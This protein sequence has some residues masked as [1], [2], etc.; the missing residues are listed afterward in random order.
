MSTDRAQGS[1]GRA[2]LWVAGAAL[3][4]GAGV[5]L[6]HQARDP[7]V[8]AP[9]AA[10]TDVPV[11]A[12]SAPAAPAPAIPP[13]VSVE[14]YSPVTRAALDEITAS[15]DLLPILRP[16]ATASANG[17]AATLGLLQGAED[18][19]QRAYELVQ[20]SVAQARGAAASAKLDARAREQLT[21]DVE[22]AT[23]RTLI[24][25][26][27]LHEVRI[28]AIATAR[29]L[30][31]FMEE[32][33]E[34]Y[35]LRDGKVRFSTPASQDQFSHFQVNTERILGQEPLA[36]NETLGALAEQEQLL[37]VLNSPN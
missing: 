25:A 11:S 24:L 27:Q 32:N 34:S 28:Q 31:T 36:R 23:S 35:E 1:R 10:P 14:S 13:E 29:S 21:A 22:A 17:R 26:R 12:P 9:A 33:A 5:V 2:R 4:I 3:T 19:A 7:G 37:A 6:V 16:D 8:S 30:V 18:S 15:V 20:Q